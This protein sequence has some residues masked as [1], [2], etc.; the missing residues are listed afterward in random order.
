MHLPRSQPCS[1]F[2]TNLAGPSQHGGQD[3]AW[4]FILL[5][6]HNPDVTPR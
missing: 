5:V 3:M 1:Q 6:P 2:T 4:A